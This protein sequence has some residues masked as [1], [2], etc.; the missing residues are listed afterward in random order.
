MPV[1]QSFGASLTLQT[2]VLPRFPFLFT[3][4]VLGNAL[5]GAFG[6]LRDVDCS[7]STG[8]KA[9]GVLG[10]V[11]EDFFAFINLLPLRNM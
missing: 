11:R 4:L 9:A 2:N 3:L 5:S 1:S 8:S 6:L 7:G 10:L